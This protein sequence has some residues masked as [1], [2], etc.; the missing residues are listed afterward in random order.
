MFSQERSRKN[1]ARTV[2][3][4]RLKRPLPEL[5]CPLCKYRSI[6]AHCSVCGHV[7]A[8]NCNLF[9]SHRVN[10][11]DNETPSQY[12]FPTDNGNNA[13]NKRLPIRLLLTEGNTLHPFRVCQF[14][15]HV[16]MYHV[17]ASINISSMMAHYLKKKRPLFMPQ[18]WHNLGMKLFSK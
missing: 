11:F 3:L 18:A 14:P 13:C 16:A 1:A 15:L 12:C 9:M 17:D 6:S 10:L 7:H 8:C 5:S 4:L 2:E